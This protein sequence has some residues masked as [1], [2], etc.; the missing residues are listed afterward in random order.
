MGKIP[1]MPTVPSPTDTIRDALQSVAKLRQQ[2]ADDAA[3][4]QAVSCIK[5]LQNGRFNGTY[6][7][8]MLDPAYSA[9]ARF[10]LEELYAD[11]DFAER[12]AQ[13]S[14][15]AGTLQKLFPASVVSTAS[16]LAELHALTETLDQSMARQYAALTRCTHTVTSKASYYLQAWR[17]VQQEPARHRQLQTVLS[18]GHDLARLTRT[19]GLRTLLKMMRKPAQAAGMGSLQQFLECGFDTFA[20]LSRQPGGAPQFLALIAERETAWINTLFHTSFPE[21]E[22]TLAATLAPRT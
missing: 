17:T 10:F 11:R 13:F 6:A 15:I 2:R 5:A 3:L 8:A 20:Q 12:D 19:P 18:I 16:A 1:C 4:A 9:A 22:A 7:D 14:R 21:A